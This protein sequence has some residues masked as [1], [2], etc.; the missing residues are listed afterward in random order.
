MP[1][2]LKTVSRKQQPNSLAQKKKKYPLLTGTWGGN[3]AHGDRNVASKIQESGFTKTHQRQLWAN[4]TLTQDLGFWVKGLSFAMGAGYDN[5]SNITENR[6]KGR[7]YG[8]EYYTGAIGD[9]NNVAEV[10]YG[11]KQDNLTFNYSVDRQWRIMQS[12]LGFYYNTSLTSD[13]NF[14]ASV[15]YTAKN[16]VRDGRHNT[17]NRANWMGTLHYDYMNKYIADLVLA[18][19]G[20]NRCYPA[21]WAFSPILSLGYIYAHDPDGLLNYGKLRASA[22]IQHTDYVPD[23]GMWLG[24]WDR[25]N[26]TPFIYGRGYSE[27]WGAFIQSF[28][29][30]NFSQEK[31][32]KLNLGTDIRLFNALDITLEGFYQQRSH[33]LHSATNMNSVTVGIQSS[34]A[35]VGGMKSYGVEAG[36]RFAKKIS[37]DLYF[38]AAGMV[39][40]SMSKYTKFIESPEYEHLS[41]INTSYNDVW[42]LE[43]IGFFK[44]QNDINNSP[45]QEFSQVRPGDIKYKDINGDGVINQFDRKTLG[46]KYNIPDLNYAFNLGLEYKGIGINAWFQGTGNFMKNFRSIEGG[47]NVIANNMNLSKDYYNNSWDIAGASAKYPRFTSQSVPNNEQSSTIWWQKVKFFKMRDCELYYKLPQKSIKKVN[48]PGAKIFVQGQNLL[49]FDNVDAMDAEVFS[50]GTYPLLKSVNIGLNVIF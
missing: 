31:S 32:S 20:S 36:A 37:K 39:T 44:D 12:F 18:A 13:D 3:A 41:L 22:G 35:D 17:H 34:F 2:S 10:L 27:V 21:K 48:L 29:T 33:I 50:S 38:N 23:A 30:K 15:V 9:K 11:N 19:N 14:G 28:P 6:S 16:E 46:S 4:T 1:N 47:W 24:N 49:S 26:G 43:A 40:W 25:H 5:A 7:Q 8:Y 45:L 42:G